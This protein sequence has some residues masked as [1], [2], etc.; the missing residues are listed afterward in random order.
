MTIWG[1]PSGRGGIE[2]QSSSTAAAML[3]DQGRQGIGDGGMIGA[4]GGIDR[5]SNSLAETGRRHR[6]P[7]RNGAAGNDSQPRA[8]AAPQVARKG[9]VDHGR[10]DFM[11]GAV[12]I[13]HSAR[14][15]GDDRANTVGDRAPRQ[16]VDQRILER[17]ERSA[18][19]AGEPVEPIG[20]GAPRMRN[21]QKNRQRVA[22]RMD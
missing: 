6:N 3:L 22:R 19:A 18:A 1:R 14:R 9:E 16:P 7:S 4:M 11:L 20:I 10:I 5:A 15:P 17:L 8:R 2:W 21:R 12:A 13:D